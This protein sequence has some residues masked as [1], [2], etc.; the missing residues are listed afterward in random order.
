[1]NCINVELS[2]LYS[3]RCG[4]N[5]GA[6]SALTGNDPV[7]AH[8]A[9]NV[10]PSQ[11]LMFLPNHDDTVTGY[12]VQLGAATLNEDGSVDSVE[13]HVACNLPC[14]VNV[15][16]PPYGLDNTL[17][18]NFAWR[19]DQLKSDGSVTTGEVWQ[20]SLMSSATFDT[21]AVADTY[22]DKTDTNFA[23]KRHMLMWGRETKTPRF[24]FVKFDLETPT[25][26]GVGGCS[27]SVMR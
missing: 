22:I 4:S 6:Y 5:V 27:V 17:G 2:A 16:R 10:R 14:G 8:G 1:M 3:G 9:K 23:D 15:C 26:A 7:P 11:E 20:F 13:W 25:Y 24:G 19:V 21:R 12:Q 18:G